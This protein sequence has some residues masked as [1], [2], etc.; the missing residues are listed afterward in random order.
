M[1]IRFANGSLEYGEVVRTVELCLKFVAAVGRGADLPSDADGLARALDVPRR[2]YPPPAAAPLWHME[3]MWLE[4]LLIPQLADAVE[5]AVP[6]GE[7]LHVRPSPHGLRVVV[8][9][10]EERLT[11]MLFRLVG[12]KFVRE[13]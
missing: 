4:D 3:R 5:A 11:E 1:E 12:G 6:G 2:G 7:V 13:A 10:P 8:E 9:G